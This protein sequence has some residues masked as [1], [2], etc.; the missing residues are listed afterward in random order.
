MNRTLTQALV[1]LLPTLPDPL[2][3]ELIDLSNS[4]L[5]QSRTRASA[6]KP[7]EEI[8]RPYA[9][10]H[11]ACE[12]LK[13]K[14]NLPKIEPRPPCA[15]RVYVK[16]YA[17]LDASIPAK[18]GRGRPPKPRLPEESNTTQ[19]G[20]AGTQH[21]SSTLAAAKSTPR[22]RGRPKKIQTPSTPNINL[23]ATDKDGL[24]AYI[25]PLIR[26]L[27]TTLAQPA[28][29]PHVFAGVA[30]VLTI[31]DPWQ[32][33]R[34][35]GPLAE[36]DERDKVGAII[37]AVYYLV[38]PRL[39]DAEVGSEAWRQELPSAMEAVEGWEGWARM[40]VGEGANRVERQDVEYWMAR[41]V[42]E[43]WL[44]LDWYRNIEAGSGLGP[45]EEGDADETMHDIA[46]LPNQQGERGGLKAGLG[47]MMQDRVDYLSPRRRA[48]AEDW[49][50]RIMRRIELLEREGNAPSQT[51]AMDV[52]A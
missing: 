13:Q 5:A 6:L 42:G 51:M 20:A 12:R 18:R 29:S 21:A 44:S 47:T 10:A 52:S 40:G 45:E 34:R 7:D 24:P 9:C 1:G 43:G 38:V 8:A 25:M 30:S 15:P 46:V 33:T 35:A 48:E 50:A 37:L 17:H 19:N 14:L 2:P 31:E 36:G 49:K 28:A 26:H 23:K 32:G 11:L 22:P 4:L 41:L 3:T 39:L 16:L 27:S